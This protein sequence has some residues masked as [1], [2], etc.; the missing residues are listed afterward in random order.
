MIDN[1]ENK[2]QG[3]LLFIESITKEKL[4]EFIVHQNEIIHYLSGSNDSFAKVL[5][6]Y[7]YSNTNNTG[8]NRYNEEDEELEKHE[9]DKRE[10]DEE[11]YYNNDKSY[12]LIACAWKKEEKWEFSNNVI[13]YP[14][15]IWMSDTKD[16]DFPI[17]LL[18][19]HPITEEEYNDLKDLFQ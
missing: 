7:C 5:K 13:N 10:K 15:D 14:I 4:A 9:E 2:I 12:Y 17:V 1:F 16:F 8:R 6:I 11:E 18:Y 19:S 3:T